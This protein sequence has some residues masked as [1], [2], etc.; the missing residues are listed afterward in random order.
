MGL[1]WRR[2]LGSKFLVFRG[3]QGFQRYQRFQG[4]VRRVLEVLGFK[5]PSVGAPLKNTFV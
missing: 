4:F 1:F 2:A 5:G 3:F